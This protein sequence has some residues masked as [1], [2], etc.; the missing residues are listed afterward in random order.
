MATL[1][2]KY[3][4]DISGFRFGRLV[5]ICPNGKNNHRK[6]MWLCQCDCGKQHITEKSH[7]TCGNT[8]SC[9]CLRA[10]STSRRRKSGEIGRGKLHNPGVHS[11]YRIWADMR[12]RCGNKNNADYPNYGGRGISVCKKWQDSFDAF[13][14]DMGPRP[15]VQHS[16]D[17]I[18]NDGNY[19]PG[20]C[21]WATAKDQANN[22]RPGGQFKQAKRGAA[23]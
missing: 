19:E 18:D 11:E 14:S 22:R 3:P 17:R 6:A 16:I 8:R 2:Q 9:G 12:Y 13:I 7:L 10:E 21:R 1:N 23:K 15:S 4:N 20:N 5:A